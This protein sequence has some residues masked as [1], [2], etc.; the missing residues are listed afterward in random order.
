MPNSRAKGKRGELEAALLLTQ[1]GLSARR[2]AQYCGADGD[3]D[4]RCNANLH[5]EVKLQ[6]QM[7]PYKWLEQ[8]IADSS[9]SKRLPLV[10]C[11][12]TRS[13][14]LV[15]M[16]ASD[17]VAISRELVDALVRAQTQHSGDT[18][19]GQPSA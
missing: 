7:H 17:W 4:L 16:R 1:L 12:R 8:A 13:P 9:K 5:V 11:R 15:I 2:S 18:T 6:E 10:L 3:A 14:W 19:Q